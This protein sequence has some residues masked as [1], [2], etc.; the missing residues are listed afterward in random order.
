M[1]V[2]LH[3]IIFMVLI[4]CVEKMIE[5]TNIHVALVNK[6]KK[7]KHYKKFLF[8]VLI[9]IGF[10]IEMAKQSLN[11]RFGKHNIPSIILGAIILGIYLEFLPYIFS[12]KEIS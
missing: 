6:I 8:I 3:F 9:I 11:A 2:V 7:Y 1:K 12:K 5:K 10:M 4:I